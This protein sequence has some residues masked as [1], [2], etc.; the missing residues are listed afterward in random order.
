MKAMAKQGKNLNAEVRVYAS[1]SQD[2]KK[3]PLEYNLKL[4]YLR[5]LAPQGVEIVQSN[6]KTPF[7]I[8]EEL[9]KEGFK[10]IYFVAGDDRK[11]E[12]ERTRKYA[13]KYGAEKLEVISA[14]KRDPDA[15]GAEGMSASKMRKAAVDDDLK[16]FLTG[17]GL[18]TKD[19]TQ[20]YNDVRK[21]M[22]I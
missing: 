19:G 6:V 13:L 18:S 11:D 12:Y 22:N 16:S 10:E 8:V 7:N 2:P 4:Q 3:N 5:K 1:H 14:G 21:G 9:A 20:L 15:K 17:T